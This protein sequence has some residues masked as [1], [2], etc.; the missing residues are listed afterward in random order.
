MSTEKVS[1][2]NIEG[3]SLENIK[4]IIPQVPQIAS[5]LEAAIEFSELDEKKNYKLEISIAL[6]Q[7]EE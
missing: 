5:I 1:R 2:L 7:A 4:A 3:K 6:V